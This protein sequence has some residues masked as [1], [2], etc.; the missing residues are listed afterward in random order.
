MVTEWHLRSFSKDIW[1]KKKCF[2]PIIAN[3]FDQSSDIGVIIALYTLS[4]Q[5]KE[6]QDCEYVNAFYL[7][8]SSLTFFVFYRIISSVAVFIGTKNIMFAIG[9]FLFEFML[10]RA[11]WVN[12]ILKCNEPCSPQKWIQNMESM[13]EAFPQLIIQMYFL[14]QTSTTTNDTGSEIQFFVIFSIAFSML[15]MTNK[16]V[17]EDKVL[18]DEQWKHPKWSHKWP[19]IKN[20]KYSVRLM[21]R[22]FDISTRVTVVVLVWYHLVDWSCSLL[23][24]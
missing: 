7:F 17:S 2:L 20:P 22:I 19:F 6:R 9:Q 12:Y 3:I 8:L 21:F 23:V 16:A 5:E 11:V 13:L 24:V 15:S 14:V 1:Q 18:F 4:M 10:Y